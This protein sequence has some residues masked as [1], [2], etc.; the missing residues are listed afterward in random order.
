MCMLTLCNA[1][2]RESQDWKKVIEQ[3]DSRFKIAQMLVPN[4]SE[5][6]IEIV[7]EG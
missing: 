3:A 5:G 1:Y 4:E 6:I 2:E 7:W